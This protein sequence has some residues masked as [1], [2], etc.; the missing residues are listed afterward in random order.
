[1]VP[2]SISVPQFRAEPGGDQDPVVLTADHSDE[3]MRRL[4]HPFDPQPA[5]PAPGQGDTA[6]G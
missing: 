2:D 6:G 4:R 1:M 3:T 5:G